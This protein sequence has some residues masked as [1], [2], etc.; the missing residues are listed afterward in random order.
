[1]WIIIYN[2]S[3]GPP[4]GV[5]SIGPPSGVIWLRKEDE[6][7]SGWGGKG[8]KVGEHDQRFRITILISQYYCTVYIDW[9][10]EAFRYICS[11]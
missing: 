11:N 6:G 10:A 8:V 2:I 3:I 9:P 4:S 1:M 7:G 5:I